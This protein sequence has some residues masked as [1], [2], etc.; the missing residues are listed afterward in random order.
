M[1]PKLYEQTILKDIIHE[2]II[3]HIT[4]FNTQIYFINLI[5]KKQS[6]Q[7]QI[8]KK[9]QNDLYN[10]LKIKFQTIYWE[11][12]HKPN[13]NVRDAVDIF[14]KYNDI[15]I[16]IE[17]DKHRADQVAKK[18]ISRNALFS[19]ENI[20]YISLCY[21]GTSNMPINET[22]KYFNYCKILSNK[23]NNDYAG[24]III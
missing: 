16:I 15:S 17:L 4:N 24:F 2:D 19:N 8:I 6:D 23:L 22:K 14:G 12:E 18:F 10:S 21:P 11:L 7:K 20:F 9:F 1:Y 5:G 3:N 13:I